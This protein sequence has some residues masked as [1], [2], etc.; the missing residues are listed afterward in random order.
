MGIRERV[1]NNAF[2][3]AGM[4]ELEKEAIQVIQK[5]RFALAMATPVRNLLVK[6]CDRLDWQKLKGE[7]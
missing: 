6:I 1:G 2:I 4:D 7:L 3:G 5:Y